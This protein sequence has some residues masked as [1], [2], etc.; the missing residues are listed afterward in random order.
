M[1]KKIN[2][3]KTMKISAGVAIV[4]KGKVLVA[5][6][7]SASWFR[8]YTPPKGGIEVGETAMDAAVRETKEEVGI[9]V[10]ETKLLDPFEI[11]YVDPK[12]KTYK[13]VILYPL[14]ISKLSEIGLT[15]EKVPIG[16]LQL[17]EVDDARF[18]SPDEFEERVLP[19]YYKPLKD[20]IDRHTK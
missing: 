15:K 1:A 16:Q 4:W 18:M 13:K 19:R 2:K 6:A 7:K 20:L 5:H 14:V 9:D 8:T 3:R 12:G 11:P 17:E 10:D